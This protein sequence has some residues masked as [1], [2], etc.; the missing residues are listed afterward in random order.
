[1]HFFTAAGLILKFIDPQ[2][3]AEEETPSLPSETAAS[4]P[5]TLTPRKS[6]KRKLDACSMPLNKK[7]YS[8]S[9]K[10]KNA[11]DHN[12]FVPKSFVEK[13]RKEKAKCK[14]N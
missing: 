13:K 12:K 8:W 9:S 6:S 1:M 5:T 4:A 14:Q 2:V 11:L 7:K 3:C 10:K